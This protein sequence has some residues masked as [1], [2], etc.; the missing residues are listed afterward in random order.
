MIRNIF[1]KFR[2]SKSGITLIEAIVTIAIFSMIF[3]ACLQVLLAGTDSWQ[4]SDVKVRLQQDLRKGMEK[5]KDDISQSGASVIT[6][7]PADGTT[8]HTITFKKAT[9][10]SSGS[11]TWDANTVN[12]VKGGTGSTQLLRTYN[13]SSRVVANNIS[14][15]DFRRVSASSNIVQVT[16]NGQL[17][18]VRGHTLTDSLSFNVQLRN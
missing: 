13:G 7:V 3:G 6:N 9:G 12:Y 17:N 11:I 2:S 18:S 8:F 15:V 16:L 10:I 5:I 1:K 4:T 14:S